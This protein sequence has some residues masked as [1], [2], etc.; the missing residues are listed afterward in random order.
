MYKNFKIL[1]ILLT[2]VVLTSI[3]NTLAV[4][5]SNLVTTL[6]GTGTKSTTIGIGSNTY[7]SLYTK[8]STYASLFSF[9][10]SRG[11]S[12]YYDA[13]VGTTVTVTNIGKVD[14]EIVIVNQKNKKYHI[15]NNYSGIVYY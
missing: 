14:N 11:T 3:G 7:P 9:K 2:A 5:N 10:T 4:N 1:G 8:S 6:T 12:P 13:P 15:L